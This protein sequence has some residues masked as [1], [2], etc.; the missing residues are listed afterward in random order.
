MQFQFIDFDIKFISFDQ[1]LDCNLEQQNISQIL[2][3]E[4]HLYYLNQRLSG[5]A[6][7]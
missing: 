2:T 6:F 5:V 4:A 1:V 3:K 7:I